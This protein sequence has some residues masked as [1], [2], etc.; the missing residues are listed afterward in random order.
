MR[1]VIREKTYAVED[2]CEK[3]ADKINIKEH[4]ELKDY[5]V[6]ISGRGELTAVRKDMGGE[7]TISVEN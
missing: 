6:Y 3:C 1:S 7:K 5:L 2:I 4:I